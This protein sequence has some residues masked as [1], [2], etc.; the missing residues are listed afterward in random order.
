MLYKTDF[1]IDAG[2]REILPIN[3]QE[4]PYGCIHAELDSAVGRSWHWHS[5]FEITYVADGELELCTAAGSVCL[6]KGDAVFINSN[7]LHDARSSKKHGSCCIF[8]HM[9]DMHFLSGIYHS[10]FEQKYFLPII[11]CRDL[12]IFVIHPDSLRK[13]RM[14]EHLLNA[15]ELNKK[16]SFGYEFKI[17]AELSA[18][19]CL[20]MEETEDLRKNSGINKNIDDERIKEMMQYIHQHYS[21]KLTL[22]S[23]ATAANISERE[24]A[25]CFARCIDMS[26]INYLNDYRIRMA[27]RML[28][29]TSKNIIEISEACG[30]SS[31]GYFGKIFQEC[32]GCTPKEYRK[33]K[34]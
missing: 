32:M 25:R 9:F 8:A 29:Q 23:I 18:F 4:F 34:G 27:G 5:T 21:E 12:Q 2:G 24:C 1:Q 7:V 20:L 15:V 16:E 31:P 19:W 3:S 10:I 30:F 11:K 6:K 13:I 17:H 26:P 28:L 14:I 22:K 33:A